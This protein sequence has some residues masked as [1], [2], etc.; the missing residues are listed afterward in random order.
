MKRLVLF[1]SVIILLLTHSYGQ[2]TNTLYFMD[3]IPQSSQLNPAFQP[4]CNL[5]IG[6]P[7]SSSTSINLGNNSL[8]LDK[9]LIPYKDSLYLFP[10]TLVQDQFL[11]ALKDENT[12][13]YRQQNDIISFGFRVQSWYFTFNSTLN[14]DF[15]ASYSKDFATIMLK[16]IHPESATQPNI[17]DLK[18][19][20]FNSSTYL[21]LGF[22]ASKQLNEELTVGAKIKFLSGI[23]DVSTDNNSFYLKSY[24]EDNIYKIKMVSDVTINAYSPFIDVPKDSGKIAFDSIKL[25]KNFIKDFPIFSS[26]GFA[27]D[28]GATYSG[29]DN[30]VLSASLLDLGFIN[31]NKSVYNFKM[32]GETNFDGIDIDI[33]SIDKAINKMVDSVKNAFT[34]SQENGAYSKSLPTKLILGAEYLPVNFFSLGLMSLTQYY[35]QQFYQQVAISANLR[36]FKMMMLSTSYSFFDNG[37]S[38]M[39]IGITYRF[40]PP[41]Q[42]YFIWDNIPIRL[43]KNF[44]PYKTRNVN[45]RFGFNWVFGCSDRKVM[46]DKPL[47]WE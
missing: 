14:T 9:I 28:F 44:I 17:Y 10:D 35:R 12:F 23:T 5:W 13:Y 32:Q 42:F 20:G 36:P 45:L 37:F 21:E 16:G 40:P 39:G 3:R 7:F 2:I 1:T 25:K 11:A 22:G 18:R 41:V 46:K 38:N 47:G 6:M 24:P 19:F 4:K 29:I 31:Y 26:K 43:A 15:S 33:D 27:F 34:F 8:S 30:I